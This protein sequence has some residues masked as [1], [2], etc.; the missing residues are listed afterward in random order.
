[1]S[2][3]ELRIPFSDIKDPNQTTKIN[4]REFQKHGLDIHKNDVQDLIDDHSAKTRILKI[5]NVKIFD[6]GRRR[7]R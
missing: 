6:M 4:I 2:D 7:G 3:I 1:M 5:K